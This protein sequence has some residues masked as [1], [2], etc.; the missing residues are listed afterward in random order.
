MKLDVKVPFSGNV[1]NAR[2][3]A[4]QLFSQI[5]TFPYAECGPVKVSDDFITFRFI[6]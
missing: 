1:R 6:Y 2:E 3:R 4:I 5:F